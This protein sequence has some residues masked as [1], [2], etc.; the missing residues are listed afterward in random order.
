MQVESKVI[1]ERRAR[2]RPSARVRPRVNGKF[3]YAGEE[4]FYVR[5]ATYGTFHASRAWDQFPPAQIVR[6][7]FASMASNG[8][9]AVRTYTVPPLWLLDEAAEKG[10]YVMVGLPWEQ[11]L[12]FLDDSTRARDIRARVR[13]GVRQCANHPAVLSYAIGNEI[14][15]PIVRW[16]GRDRVQ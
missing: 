16:H 15:A 10:L 4:K 12:T 7:D 2:I 6:A 11:H 5:G 9:N 1:H 14:P 13:A 8:I 3:L